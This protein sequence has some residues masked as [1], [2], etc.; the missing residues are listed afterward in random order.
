L[1]EAHSYDQRTKMPAFDYTFTVNAPLTAVS[2]FHRDTR[3]LKKLT[4]PPI[5]VQIH[6][7]EPL[8]E[9]S[10]A[11][12]TMWFGPLPL[13]WQAVH[14]DVGPHGFTDTQAQGPLRYWQHTHRFTAVS[15]SQT[16]I[17]E[18]IEYD[19]GYGLWGLFTHLLF[20]R[21][22][23]CALFTARKLLTRWHL[24]QAS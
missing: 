10:V 8:G 9:G 14:S 3:I 23:L 21:P 5:F 4:P 17:H 20:N 13:R 18:H 7:F 15:D 12:F 22:G 1:K 2:D 11:E 6:Q 16:Q 24:R 19:Y